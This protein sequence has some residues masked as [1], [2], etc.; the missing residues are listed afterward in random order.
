MVV[1]INYAEIRNYWSGKKKG[2]ILAAVF[3]FLSKNLAYV[4]VDFLVL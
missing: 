3:F 4:T 2:K 1:Y